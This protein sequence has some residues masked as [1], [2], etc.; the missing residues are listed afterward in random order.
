MQKAFNTIKK[1]SEKIALRE[2]GLASKLTR[3]VFSN[4]KSELF[5]PTWVE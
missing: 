3:G 1:T 5:R 2:I 4:K